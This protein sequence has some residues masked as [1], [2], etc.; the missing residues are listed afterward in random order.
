[1]GTRKPKKRTLSGVESRGKK[2]KDNGRMSTLSL[3]TSQFLF[4]RQT[5]QMTERHYECSNLENKAVQDLLF[6]TV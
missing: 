4:L 2:E 3:H 6:Q 5:I 1:M